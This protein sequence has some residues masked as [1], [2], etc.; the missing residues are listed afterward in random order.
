MEF[1]AELDI[2]NIEVPRI[3]DPIIWYVWKKHT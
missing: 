1:W 3:D 2:Q